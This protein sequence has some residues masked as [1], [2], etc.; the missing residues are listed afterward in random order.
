VAE[1]NAAILPEAGCEACKDG[2]GLIEGSCKCGAEA[3]GLVSS[4]WSDYGHFTPEQANA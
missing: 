4:A 2:K 3:S 1:R